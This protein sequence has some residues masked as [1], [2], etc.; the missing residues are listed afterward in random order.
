MRWEWQLLTLGGRDGSVVGSVHCVPWPSL[1][2]LALTFMATPQ[3]GAV[4]STLQGPVLT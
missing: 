3:E 1:P 2:P 4:F